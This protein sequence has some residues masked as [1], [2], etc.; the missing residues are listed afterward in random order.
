MEDVA[1]TLFPR[2]TPLFEALYVVSGDTNFK[3]RLALL[4][5]LV[6]RWSGY[7][8]ARQCGLFH[9]VKYPLRASV[10][11]AQLTWPLFR[12]QLAQER[13]PL[14]PSFFASSRLLSLT[15]SSK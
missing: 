14:F 13:R 2:E 10:Q 9:F 12:D 5:G 4:Y 11:L 15:F 6:Q 3:L 7:P 1:L 8:V